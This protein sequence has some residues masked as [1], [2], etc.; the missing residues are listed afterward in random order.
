MRGFMFFQVPWK[1]LTR[2]W[3]ET[4]DVGVVYSLFLNRSRNRNESGRFG[5]DLDIR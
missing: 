1:D 2:D 5:R 4:L 3:K